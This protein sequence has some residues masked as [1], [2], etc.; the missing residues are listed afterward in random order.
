MIFSKDILQSALQ[1]L[2]LVCKSIRILCSVCNEPKLFI[3]IPMDLKVSVQIRM[4]C[5]NN[6]YKVNISYFSFLIPTVS[7]EKNILRNTSKYQPRSAIL[8]CKTEKKYSGYLAL[9]F[10][11]TSLFVK[12]RQVLTFYV[13]MNINLIVFGELLKNT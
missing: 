4:C 6:F 10:V 12:N 2:I 11:S 5:K 1:L 7:Q 9:L 13:C 8:V 3:C